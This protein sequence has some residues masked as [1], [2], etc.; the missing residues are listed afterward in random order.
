MNGY[1]C[2]ND[3]EEV[4]NQQINGTTVREIYR[5]LTKITNGDLTEVPENKS[6]VEEVLGEPMVEVRVANSATI[7]TELLCFPKIS[8]LAT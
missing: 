8:F 7:S 2:D 4:Q 6:K 3:V 1:V 5:N